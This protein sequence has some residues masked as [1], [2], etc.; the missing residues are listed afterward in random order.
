MQKID[1][2]EKIVQYVQDMIVTEPL[3]S[4]RCEYLFHK[5]YVVEC[6]QRFVTHSLINWNN[7]IVQFSC[8][9]IV[10]HLC[11]LAHDFN[12]SEY[13]FALVK[14][15]K[16]VLNQFDCEGLAGLDVLCPHNLTEATL[17]EQLGNLVVVRNVAPNCRQ[18]DLVSVK[19]SLVV[20]DYIFNYNH[21]N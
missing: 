12:F 1:A 11:K 9:Q 4:R 14:T 5:K 8:E 21:F 20:H 16:N 3:W 7:N 15:V 10:F 6:F 18:V 13:F 17:A 2:T 19:V